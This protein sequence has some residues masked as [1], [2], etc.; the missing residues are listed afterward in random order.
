MHSAFCCS[1]LFVFTINLFYANHDNEKTKNNYLELNFESSEENL[2]ESEVD[3]LILG[4]LLQNIL[5][6]KVNYKNGDFY[7]KL[8]LNLFL[9]VD[10]P[11]PEF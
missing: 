5:Y 4:L 7:K 1:I 3:S 6:E 2:D 11:P 8:K 10:S 9:T